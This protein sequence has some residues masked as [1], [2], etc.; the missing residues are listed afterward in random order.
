MKYCKIILFSFCLL[1]YIQALS[2]TI[3]TG[4]I[5]NAA[6]GAIANANILLSTPNSTTTLAYGISDNAGNFKVTLNTKNDSIKITVSCIGYS[7]VEKNILNLSQFSIFTLTENLTELPTVVVKNSPISLQGDTTNYSTSFF[8]SKQDRVIGDVLS[9]IPGIEVDANGLITYNGK[10]ISNYYIDGLDLLGTKYNIANQNIPAELVDKIQLLNNHQAI[11]AL[12]SFTTNK[13]TAINIKLKTK[14]K[15]RIISKAKISIGVS[16]LLW[17]NE[18]TALNFRKN[19]Q[20]ISAYKNNN[21]GSYLYSELNDN[22]AIKQLGEENDNTENVKLLNLVSLPSIN[23]TS[24]RYTFNNSHLLHF[25]IL[26]LMK[27]KA[28]LKLNVSQY[29]DDN[30][31]NGSNTIRFF[32]PND[33]ISFKEIYVTFNKENK[34]KSELNYTINTK[35]YYLN[36]L[37]TYKNQHS[38]ETGNIETTQP[39]VQKLSSNKNNISNEFLLNRLKN[40]TL[41]SI[42][43]KLNYTDNPQQLSVF[44]GTFPDVFNAGANF[45]VLTQKSNLKNLS[46]NTSISVTIKKKT[47][48]YANKLGIETSNINLESYFLNPLN[49]RTA[50][51][52][53]SLTN[54]LA[55]QNIKPYMLNT[56]S[57]I[58]KK[59]TFELT[60]PM[61]TNFVTQKDK[62]TLREKSYTNVFINPRFDLTIPLTSKFELQFGFVKQ[63]SVKSI[64]DTYNGYI[65]A[66]Y[67]SLRH[68]DS[69]IPVEKLNNFKGSFAYK[70]PLKGLFIYFT[71]SYSILQ[72]NLLF[73]NVYNN[74]LTKTLAIQKWNNQYNILLTGYLNK[75]FLN[76]KTNFSII[77]VGG[78]LKSL[79]LLQNTETA[80][81]SIRKEVKIKISV[82]K[83]SWGNFENSLSFQKNNSKLFQLGSKISEIQNFNIQNNTKIYF[84]LNSKLS[85]SINT[86]YYNFTNTQAVNSSYLFVDFGLRYKFKLIDIEATATNITNNKIFNATLITKNTSQEYNSK[87][88][89]ANA[90]VRMYFSF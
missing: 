61:E 85:T 9:K 87:I 10:P 8:S 81:S 23:L 35:K 51:V 24:K 74:T 69:I 72:K 45:L 11:R 78:K 31:A 68:N 12:D 32:L 39:I 84:F 83:F 71:G 7:K 73:S 76:A 15:N 22:Y 57:F 47:L 43:C 82:N 34:F 41:L 1:F 37:F 90:L 54:N 44:P 38:A 56:L 52:T 79:Q 89:P 58:K 5:K 53:D 27:N 28:Q 66:N 80:I 48:Q 20:L 40:K 59:K 55:W 33:T 65:L 50:L 62:N 3:F 13:G 17:D 86:D 70:N 46:T 88:R 42:S 29:L 60:I 21:S 19:L 64:I 30:T 16:P 25:N 36:N 49:N 63:T 4:Q 2:Q 6:S 67:R 75:Y 18:I 77:F 26:T 14:A